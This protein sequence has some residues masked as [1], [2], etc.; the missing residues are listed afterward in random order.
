MHPNGS[1]TIRRPQVE[2]TFRAL[3]RAFQLFPARRDQLSAIE[4][5]GRGAGGGDALTVPPGWV[6]DGGTALDPCA[7]RP[8]RIVHLVLSA[9]EYVDYHPARIRQLAHALDQRGAAAPLDKPG[10]ARIKGEW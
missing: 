6:D 3:G 2:S 7:N 10:I 8:M 9:C 4:A 5:S 1:R